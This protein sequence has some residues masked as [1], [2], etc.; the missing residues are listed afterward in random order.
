MVPPIATLLAKSALVDKYR[1][2]LKDI[3]CGAA[4]LGQEVENILRQRFPGLVVRQCKNFF[5]KLFN[6]KKLF[7]ASLP[8]RKF[9]RTLPLCI[10][11][12]KL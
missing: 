9:Y 6:I 8:F 2:H 4:A 3:A 11:P 10:K 12:I 7:N 5:F 1:L